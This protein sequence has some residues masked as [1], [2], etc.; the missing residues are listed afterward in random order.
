MSVPRVA[1]TPLTSK[2]PEACPHCGSHNVTRRGTR[3]KKLE[4]MQ[5]W[6]CAS[7]KRVFTPGPAALHNK[8][9]PLRMIIAALSDYNLGYSL[10]ETAARLK[11][12]TN[13]RVSPSTIT[14]WLHEYR[15]QSSYHRLR[16]AGLARFPAAETI[17]SIKLYHRQIYA[18]AYHRPKL[19]FVRAGTLDDKRR[20]D[21]RFAALA[22]FL[23]SIPTTC[24]H[25][26]FRRD[27]DPK[28]R[29]SQAH[30]D[31]ADVSRI[32]VNRKQNAATEAAALIIPA[33]GNN[34][35]RHETLQRFMLANDSV[36]VAIEI[37]IWLTEPDIAA[38]ERQHGVELAPRDAGKRA[39]SPATS[40]FYR[41][42]TVRCTFSTTSR[43]RVPTSRSPSWRSTRWR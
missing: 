43:M 42:G 39:R 31:F 1:R 37:P 40:I 2:Q 26:L 14:A 22:D 35:L 11:K 9:Y 27:D 34:K 32:I 21:T 15:Q 41:S 7:C 5:L 6:R 16:A 10:A 28:A 38:L 30:P 20:G 4:I 33:V 8:T 3:R 29:A 13:R 23:E 17:R 25:D 19:E 12:K 18:Y 36:T 24:P